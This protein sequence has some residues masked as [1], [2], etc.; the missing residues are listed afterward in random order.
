MLSFLVEMS[1]RSLPPF[2][3]LTSIF[4]CPTSVGIVPD[5]RGEQEY[6]K[7]MPHKWEST[8]GICQLLTV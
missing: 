3:G 1:Y 2:W 7:G 8:M 6:Q 4:L 5:Q